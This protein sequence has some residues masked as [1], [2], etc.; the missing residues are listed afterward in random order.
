MRLIFTILEYNRNPS[1]SISNFLYIIQSEASW[2]KVRNEASLFASPP[3]D[4]PTPKKSGTLHCIST[5][6]YAKGRSRIT[7]LDSS[8]GMAAPP[9]FISTTGGA[10]HELGFGVFHNNASLEISRAYSTTPAGLA[11]APL[12]M[13][14]KCGILWANAFTGRKMPLARAQQAEELVGIGP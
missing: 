13:R 9:S 1:I 2:R 11:Q 8:A 7:L 3:L 10:L 4:V 5:I 6:I 14:A 12:K